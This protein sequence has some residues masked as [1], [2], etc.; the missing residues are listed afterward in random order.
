MTN[1]D[2]MPLDRL[3][4]LQQHGSGEARTGA[5]KALEARLLTAKPD[6]LP[7]YRTCV[8]ASEFGTPRPEIQVDVPA[9]RN[10][11]ELF[12]VLHEL[13]ARV[14]RGLAGTREAW[15]VELRRIDERKGAV[16]LEL[17]DGTQREVD[18]G[19]AALQAVTLAVGEATAR[20]ARRLRKAAFEAQVE[21]AMGL[22]QEQDA[23]VQAAA[24]RQLPLTAADEEMP[25][26]AV[27]HERLG[28]RLTAELSGPF[29]G[30]GPEGQGP[31]LDVDQAKKARREYRRLAGRKADR[32]Q[33]AQLKRDRATLPAYV[34]AAIDGGYRGAEYWSWMRSE[35][36]AAQIKGAE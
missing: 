10:R 7:T 13:A 34:L 5:R 19:M 8:T 29:E 6:E 28:E 35:Y 4:W 3:R 9:A 2:D 1:Y 36:L 12:V 24:D 11:R 14:E 15:H 27:A 33:A 25:P 23:R 31:E 20:P 26:A 30:A 16:Y 22:Q 17:M 18:R 21:A 32:F